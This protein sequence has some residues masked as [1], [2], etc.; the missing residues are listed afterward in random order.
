MEQSSTGHSGCV[1]AAGHCHGQPYKG[2]PRRRGLLCF[3]RVYSGRICIVVCYDE[4]TMT[5]TALLQL[6][7]FIPLS[8]AA[9]RLKLSEKLLRQMITTGRIKGAM[10]SSGEIGVSEIDLDQSITREE[11]DHLRGKAITVPEAVEKYGINPVTI[12]NWVKHSY[13][14][15]LK[16]GYGMEIDGADMAYCAAVYRAQGGMQGKRIFDE[17]GQPYLYKGTEWATY[18]RERRRKKSNGTAF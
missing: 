10:L 1:C 13:I 6:D 16:S 18:Q 17:S 11:F 15:I 5:T 14:K 8:K 2:M 7:R 9:H 4:A 3:G 12:R